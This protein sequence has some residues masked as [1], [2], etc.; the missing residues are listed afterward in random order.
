MLSVYSNAYLTVG[1]SRAKD[2][3][4][5]LFG[6]RPTRKYVEFEYTSGHLR[7]QVLA[8]N[9]SRREQS[10]PDHYITLSNEPLSDRGW[11]LQERVV[12]RRMLH[13]GTPQMFFEC[14]QGFQ[15]EDGVFLEG[16]F[17]SIH[18]KPEEGPGAREQRE[19][20]ELNGLGGALSSKTALLASWY[21]LLWLYGPQKLTRPSDKLPAISGL[22]EIFAKRLDD[23][24][25][26]GLWRSDLI[27]G[28]LWQGLNCRRRQ[29]YRAPSWSWASMDGIPGL[30][31]VHDYDTL[32]EVL[33][34][35]VNLKSSNPYGEVT[36]AKIT[37]RAPMERLYLA[38]KDWDPTKATFPYE[39]NLKMRTANGKPE[40]TRSRFDFA[41]TAEDAVQEALKIAK[42]LEGIEVFALVLLK[43][44][45]PRENY[46]ALIVSKVVGAE[47]YQRLGFIHLGE[48]TLGRRPEEEA[49]DELPIVTLV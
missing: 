32:A 24:Y 13:Y 46:Q 8:F 25:V 43:L 2:C 5:G 12:S 33:D 3:S 27:E 4:E 14:N 23:Q 41:F 22:A 44:K 30:G 29:E 15:G 19:F 45:G 48:E 47:E 6:E 49:K 9:L 39:R 34:V 1:A 11:G 17:E 21:N 16:R 35:K 7:G 10:D 26:A 36:D 37:I 28:L 38:T 20:R 18:E 40:G 42:N 31:N